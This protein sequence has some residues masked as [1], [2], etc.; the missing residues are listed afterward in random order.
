MSLSVVTKIPSGVSVAKLCHLS[1]TKLCHFH[2]YMSRSSLCCF[3]RSLQCII[4]PLLRLAWLA[5]LFT[6]ILQWHVLHLIIQCCWVF[7]L[8]MLFVV[9]RWPTWCHYW[10]M[11]GCWWWCISY[12]GMC[13]L[14]ASLTLFLRITEP[15][16]ASVH[17]LSYSR[18]T[19]SSCI[20]SKLAPLKFKLHF[21]MLWILSQ[22]Q[23]RSK[24]FG[25]H[26]L[27]LLF[28]YSSQSLL[29]LTLS[30][31]VHCFVS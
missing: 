9:L 4:I 7:L 6:R 12:M 30:G 26:I 16:A 20:S 18:I 10:P 8:H 29:L 3:Y 27:C 1:S 25:G 19:S 14:L 24:L 15:C 13:R 5:F 21:L 28:S 11:M 31:P 17:S 23:L 2:Y 22:L